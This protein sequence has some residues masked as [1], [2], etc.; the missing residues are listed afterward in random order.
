[1]ALGVNPAKGMSCKY[2][3]ADPDEIEVLDKLVADQSS[4]VLD[5]KA[6]K[7][8]ENPAAYEREKAA[9]AMKVKDAELAAERQENADLRKKLADLEK[10]TR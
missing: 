5:E 3:T 8:L 7:K 1:V 2:E 4:A 10:R 6:W 9:E